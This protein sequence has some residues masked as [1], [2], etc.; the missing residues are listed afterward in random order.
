[1]VRYKLCFG[2]IAAFVLTLM[3]IGQLPAESNSSRD[4][5][6]KPLFVSDSYRSPGSGHKIIVYAHEKEAQNRIL[7]E[8]GSMIADYGAF[9]LFVAPASAADFVAQSAAGSGM[10]DDMNLIQL[11][12][13]AFDTTE[14]EP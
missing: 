9:S 1:M 5:R 4:R 3:F 12:A 14:G 11:R 6:V 8:G 2:F 7:S 13:G 10:R